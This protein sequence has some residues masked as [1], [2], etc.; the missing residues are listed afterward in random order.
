MY[1]ISIYLL[2]LLFLPSFAQDLSIGKRYDKIKD[3]WPNSIGNMN[4]LTILEYS[5]LNET[6]L[7]TLYFKQKRV[8]GFVFISKDGKTPSQIKQSIDLAIQELTKN[9]GMPEKVLSAEISDSL[10]SPLADKEQIEVSQ[11]TKNNR[12]YKLGIIKKSD[13]YLLTYSGAKL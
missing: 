9:N 11:W 10:L 7:A 3:T 1:K 4:E 6:V 2:C 12:L 5:F 8:S 13:I